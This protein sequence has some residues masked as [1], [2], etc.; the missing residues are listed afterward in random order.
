MGMWEKKGSFTT[1]PP[2]PPPH[3]TVLLLLPSEPVSHYSCK[4]LP[5]TDIKIEN[6]K[7]MQIPCLDIWSMLFSGLVLH[8]IDSSHLFWK[9]KDPMLV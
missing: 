9:F 8:R 2:P 1:P 4:N 7:M 3:A 6:I 5:K